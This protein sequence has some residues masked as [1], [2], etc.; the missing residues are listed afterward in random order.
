MKVPG[1]AN[2]IS[3]TETKTP[4]GVSLRISTIRTLS[5]GGVANPNYILGATMHDFEDSYNA[6]PY[7]TMI[8][9]ENS[10]CGLYHEAH[11]TELEA[12]ERHRSIVEMV[13]MGLEFPGVTVTAETGVPTM[14]LVDWEQRLARK[15]ATV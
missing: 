3:Y 2:T 14:T 10:M 6:W 9:P 11:E 15:V 4:A 7:E 8:F 12:A 13:E 5:G 1:N